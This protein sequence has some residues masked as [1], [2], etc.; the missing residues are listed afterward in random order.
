MSLY[1]GSIV[2]KVREMEGAVAFWSAAL[3]YVPRDPDPGPDW[4]VLTD[5][6]RRWA[7]L[8][9][10]LTDEP[11]AVP[12]RLH[13]DLYTAD[14][15]AEVTRLEGL[16]ATRLGTPWNSNPDA[17][18]VVLADPDGNEFCVVRSSYTQG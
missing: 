3:G 10:Q 6:R 1:I 12:N 14:Q 17:D 16:G 13:L 15:A 2:V 18:F 4:V 5:P 7:N 8:S 11:K 9:L